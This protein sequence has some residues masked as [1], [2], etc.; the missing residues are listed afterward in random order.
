MRYPRPDPYESLTRLRERINH[1]LTDTE[2][3][4]MQ[5]PATDGPVW[6]PRVDI[7][8]TPDEIVVSVDLCG[9]DQDEISVE[10]TGD[11]MTISG[12]RMIVSTSAPTPS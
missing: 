1:L 3:R 9:L 2:R 12:E 10:I 4:R 7:A 5:R 6:A 11:T 8:E